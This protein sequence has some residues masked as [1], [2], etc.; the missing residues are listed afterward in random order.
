MAA[1]DTLRFDYLLDILRRPEGGDSSRNPWSRCRFAVL[2]LGIPE[3][4][5][6]SH[7]MRC[8]GPC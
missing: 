7:G 4:S 5:P 3:A 1:Q 6:R 8:R 2:W